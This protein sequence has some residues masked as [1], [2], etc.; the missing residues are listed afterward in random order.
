ML[1]A[2]QAAPE[3]ARLADRWLA[4]SGVAPARHVRVVGV[5]DV[6]RRAVRE[7][8]LFSELSVPWATAP[9][10]ALIRDGTGQ[11]TG[12]D[13]KRTASNGDTG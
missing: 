13:G 8:A 2:I 5:N 10:R 1:A 6:I 12:E 9:Y 4:V 3:P 7:G 11:R